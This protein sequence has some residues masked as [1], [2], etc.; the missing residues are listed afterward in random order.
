MN[1][2]KL[3][4]FNNIALFLSCLLIFLMTLIEWFNHYNWPYPMEGNPPSMFLYA[5]TWIVIS[6]ALI[7]ILFLISNPKALTPLIFAGI[8]NIIAPLKL[9]FSYGYVNLD[10]K[11]WGCLYVGGP[12]Q[13]WVLLLPLCFLIPIPFF[14]IKR[15]KN[16]ISPDIIINALYGGA[17]IS[18]LMVSGAWF[19]HGWI[20]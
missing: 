5:L 6:W 13:L 16:V 4:K 2:E 20:S 1:K 15:I 17:I 19:T 18:F 12:L 9:M 11:I 8:I 3:I 7:N 10:T 14:K